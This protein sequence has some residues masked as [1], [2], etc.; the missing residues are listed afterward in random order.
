[1]KIECYQQQLS[2]HIEYEL[3]NI[4]ANFYQKKISMESCF[5]A[6]PLV[7]KKNMSLELEHLFLMLLD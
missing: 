1:M 2:F 7:L 3:V 4:N 6:F 5:H